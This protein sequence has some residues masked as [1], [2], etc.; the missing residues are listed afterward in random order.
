MIVQDTFTRVMARLFDEKA[1]ISVPTGFQAFF[2]NPANG[3]ETIFS[4]DANDVDIDIIRGN[5]KTAAL[6]PRGMVSRPLGPN[7]RNMA[8]E[9]YTSFSRSY[10]LSEEESDITA[11]Q[12]EKRVAGEN[13]YQIRSRRD[14]MRLLA[15]KYHHENIRRHV[16]L[17]E[18]LAAQSILTGKMDAI[19]GTSNPDLQYDFRRN[20]DL[21][22]TVTTGWNQVGADIMGDIDGRCEDLR[23]IGHENPDFMGLGGEAMSSFIKDTTIQG[24][25]DNRRIEL[26]EVSTNNPVPAKFDRFVAAG[27]TPRGRLRTLKGYTLWMFT[28]TDVYTDSTT[29]LPV[30][31]LPEDQ[32]FIAYTGARMDRYFGPPEL[33]PSISQKEQF[34]Q[35]MFG[36]GTN[37]APM[38]MNIKSP[39]GVILPQMFYPDA[40]ISDNWKKVSIRTQSA[41]IYA[42]TQTD[43]VATLLG[44]IT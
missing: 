18:R 12:L 31:Y 5:E 37:S 42:T 33:L 14:K 44:L 19:L 26:I 6:I 20:S 30:K 36:F 40:Y 13:P 23:A 16:R 3:S 8:A 32:A 10:P 41:P 24:L 43:S 27:W 35:E 9:N 21:I 4:P 34:M 29:D 28:Y 1:I 15:V 11:K 7:Q 17:F 25:A 38:P 2:G 39:A 22:H